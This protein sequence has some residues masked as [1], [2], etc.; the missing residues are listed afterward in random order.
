M[1]S[2]AESHWFCRCVESANRHG[3][4]PALGVLSEIVRAFGFLGVHALLVVQPLVSGLPGLPDVHRDTWLLD[5]PEELGRMPS[6]R[7]ELDGW[8]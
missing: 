6:L 5:H 4:T 2:T 1:N 7:R 3:L 8:E